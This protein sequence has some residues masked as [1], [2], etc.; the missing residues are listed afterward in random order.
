MVD[1]RTLATSPNETATLTS[2]GSRQISSNSAVSARLAGPIS[3]VYLPA[4][5]RA[6]AVRPCFNARRRSS[7]ATR[8]PYE[9]RH[10]PQHLGREEPQ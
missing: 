4:R 6:M 9:R 7:S 5:Y 10:R 1:D 8:R 2:A 3:R